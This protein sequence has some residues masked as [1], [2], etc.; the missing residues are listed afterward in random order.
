LRWETLELDRYYRFEC[1][2]GEEKNVNGRPREGE[3]R[4]EGWK[5]GFLRACG[6][7]R[8]GGEVVQ[9][10]FG[11]VKA[12]GRHRDKRGFF[13]WLRRERSRLGK[14]RRVDD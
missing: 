4:R 1:L 13:G 5:K 14:K 3:G 2:K 10:C 11:D 6:L 8:R 12:G 9:L 7:R